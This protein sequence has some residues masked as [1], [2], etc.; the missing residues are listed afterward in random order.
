MS[1]YIPSNRTVPAA[2]KLKHAAEYIDVSPITIRRL[3]QRG[4][5]KP[6]RALRH[7]IIPVAELDRFLKY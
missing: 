6:S 3:I 7:I 5:I 4:L 1:N 2:L